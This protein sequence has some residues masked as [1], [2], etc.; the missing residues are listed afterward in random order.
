M[1]PDN[2]DILNNFFELEKPCP[3]EI[4]GCLRI[5]S[6]YA[7]DIKKLENM[8]VCSSCLKR[9]LRNKYITYILATNPNLSQ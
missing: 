9:S 4:Q 2:S 8:G 3:S 5:R 6:E 7:E 1:K